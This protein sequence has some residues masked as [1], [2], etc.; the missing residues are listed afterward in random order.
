MRKTS[1]ES[2]IERKREDNIKSMYAYK[3][4]YTSYEI[5]NCERGATTIHPRRR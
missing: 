2:I 1:I 3:S 4:L 5:Y